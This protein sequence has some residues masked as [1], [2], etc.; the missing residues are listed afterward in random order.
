[1]IKKSV[2]KAKKAQKYSLVDFVGK[3][4]KKRNC[5]S[6]KSMLVYIYQKFRLSKVSAEMALWSDSRELAKCHKKNLTRYFLNVNIV[7]TW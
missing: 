2:E 6:A 5:I 4:R 3:N 1:M 7:L